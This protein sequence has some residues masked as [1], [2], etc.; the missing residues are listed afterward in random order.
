[1]AYAIVDENG[2]YVKRTSPKIEFTSNVNEAY[3]WKREKSASN[4][5][6]HSLHNHNNY[7]SRTFRVICAD[8][9]CNGRY[10]D[11]STDDTFTSD[12][13]EETDDTVITDEDDYYSDDDYYIDDDCSDASD[14]Y[15]YICSADFEETN[16]S[17]DNTS[18]SDI[19]KE[20]GINDF[21][22]E[23]NS[24]KETALTNLTT[25]NTFIDCVNNLHKIVVNKERVDYLSNMLSKLDSAVIDIEHAIEF[26]KAG[27]SDGYKY[28]ILLH[29]ILEKRR[30]CKD[31]L[32][33]IG[34]IKDCFDVLY[35]YNIVKSISGFDDRKYK[36][37]V[38]NNLFQD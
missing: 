9:Y 27:M 37:R 28:C 17:F 32:Q 2:N 35:D 30:L 22:S 14:D 26:N 36:P 10:V 5:V 19:S 25:M 15:D 4:Y 34:I 7:K 38:L 6:Q 12:D 23:S 11:D 8:D 21:I 16:D 1:M 24:L 20:L 31:E 33:K 3:L 29:D 18:I 13:F